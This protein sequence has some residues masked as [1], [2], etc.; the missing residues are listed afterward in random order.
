VVHGQSIGDGATLPAWTGAAGA[1]FANGPGFMFD[2]NRKVSE[3]LDWLLRIAPDYLLTYP[4]LL[5]EL[6]RESR[7]RGVRPGRLRAVKL[8]GE[9]LHDGLREQVREDWGVPLYDVY[10][11][12]ET[13][14]LALQCP[15]NEH[16]HVT[17]EAA[18]VEILDRAD[19]PCAPG[20]IGRVVVTPLHNFAMPLIRYDIGD[21]AEVG[22]PCSCGRGLPVLSR[23]MGRVRN[24]LIL[25]D[26]GVTWPNVQRPITT[27]GLPVIQFQIVQRTRT[28]LE[29]RLVVARPLTAAEEDTLRAS[30]NEHC[31][32]AFDIS[33]TYLPEIARGPGGKYE[34]FY[35]EVA[36]P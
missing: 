32:A 14:Y 12:I 10:S 6:L 18:V 5:K 3:Q 9:Q 33:F 31:G 7:R 16:Y 30:L 34:D 29:A 20:E 24:M 23:I 17:A 1:T 19:R 4:S 13:G 28:A 27:C 11:A 2:A 21:Y 15:E 25:P 35:S 26:G 22:P 36:L 8:F